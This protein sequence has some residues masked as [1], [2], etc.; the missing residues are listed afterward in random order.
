MD[1]RK[2]TGSPQINTW[3]L[4]FLSEWAFQISGE[5]R[6]HEMNHEEMIA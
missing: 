4:M 6:N 1:Q 3:A 2:K 5:R